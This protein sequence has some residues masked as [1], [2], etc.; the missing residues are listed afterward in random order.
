LARLLDINVRTLDR[1]PERF[2]HGGE[3]AL[4]NKSKSG[5]PPQ[6]NGAQLQ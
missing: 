2:H 5:R 4:R 1:W 3:E 6:L